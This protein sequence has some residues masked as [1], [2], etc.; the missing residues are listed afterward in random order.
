VKRKMGHLV[1][2]YEK[3]NIEAESVRPLF[4]FNPVLITATADIEDVLRRTRQ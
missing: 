1:L 2:V 3:G 4:G